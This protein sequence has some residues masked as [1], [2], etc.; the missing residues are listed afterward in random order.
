MS[1]KTIPALT[2]AMRHHFHPQSQTQDGGRSAAFWIDSLC[3]PDTEP[4]RSA[5]LGSMGFIYS[6]ASTVAV[7]LSTPLATVL[8]HMTSNDTLNDDELQIAERDEWVRSVWTYQEVV[9]SQAFFVAITGNDVDDYTH[10]A[11]GIFSGLGVRCSRFLDCLGH[12]LV[13]YKRR[14]DSESTPIDIRKVF[15]GLDALDDVVA[16]SLTSAWSALQVM[17]N[18][19]RRVCASDRPENR[20]YSMIGTITRSPG[21]PLY[22]SAS[23]GFGQSSKPTIPDLAESFMRI[24]EAKG[25]FSFIFSSAERDNAVG[26][27][28]RPSAGYIPSILSWHSYGD[29]LR[30]YYDMHGLWFDDVHCVDAFSS[31]T[32][33]DAARQIVLGWLHLTGSLRVISDTDIANML[34]SRLKAIGFTGSSESIITSRG[35]FFPQTEIRPDA[36]TQSERII[37]IPAKLQWTFGYPALARIKTDAVGRGRQTSF[38]A[39]VF[40]GLPNAG[41][42]S[43]LIDPTAQ[44]NIS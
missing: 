2:A 17:S 24:C 4:S 28:W 20:F 11:T 1:D 7:C 37:I 22:T 35:I 19:D 12:S 26:R 40:A 14:H 31:A 10:G 34:S 21:N 3:I 27:R 42:S 18:I 5:T 38:V 33:E 6:Q 15:P 9:N 44:S 39:G 16:D 36:N 25:D 43:F 8:D 41:A 23:R 30:G 13:S 29:G 32:L